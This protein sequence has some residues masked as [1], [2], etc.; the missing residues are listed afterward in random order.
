MR[1]MPY[2]ETGKISKKNGSKYW[3]LNRMVDRFY[4]SRFN[5]DNLHGLAEGE[6][7]DNSR[8]HRL[9]NKA[10][11]K[12]LLHLFFDF[13]EWVIPEENLSKIYLTDNM[14]LN[15]SSKLPTV[16]RSNIVDQIKTKGLRPIGELYVTNGRYIWTLE[17]T[18]SLWER[19]REVQAKDPEFI[20]KR[21]EL[22]K[23]VEER[24]RN[25]RKDS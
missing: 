21:E 7:I 19:H 17:M 2:N 22:Q 9:F 11:I 15:R 3:T 10:D 14:M 4:C 20:A 16:R 1:F 18:G 6:D 24:N 8:S 13:M 12:E 25:E 23:S 5:R